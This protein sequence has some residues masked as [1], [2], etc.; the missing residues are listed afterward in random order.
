M[1]TACFLAIGSYAVEQQ[2]RDLHN[3]VWV[4]LRQF[5][6]NRNCLFSNQAHI[7]ASVNPTCPDS[8]S[9]ITNTDVQIASP[10]TD[11]N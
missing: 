7:P 10:I 3:N 8:E 1:Q 6:C 5:I 11:N 4:I 2:H 9:P